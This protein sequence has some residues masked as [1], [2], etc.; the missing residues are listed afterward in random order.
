MGIDDASAETYA[1]DVVVSDFEAPGDGDV[2]Q[3][4]P[5]RFDWQGCGIFGTSCPGRDG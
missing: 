4:R 3:E 1:K 2:L 5:G